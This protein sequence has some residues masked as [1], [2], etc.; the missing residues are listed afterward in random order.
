MIDLNALLT[1]SRTADPNRAA[2]VTWYSGLAMQAMIAKQGIPDSESEREEIALWAHRMAEA[3][4]GV[5]RGLHASGD[6]RHSVARRRP[7]GRP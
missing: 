2:K 6:N 7:A 1:A 3:M 5:A 4:V